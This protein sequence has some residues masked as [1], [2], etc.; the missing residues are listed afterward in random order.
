MARIPRELKL[1]ASAALGVAFVTAALALG[2]CLGIDFGDVLDGMPTGPNLLRVTKSL[3]EE[4]VP[5]DVREECLGGIDL[6]ERPMR[7][8][9]IAI[10]GGKSMI[11]FRVRLLTPIA[12]S[13]VAFLSLQLAKLLGFRVI[14]VADA[15]KHGSLLVEAGADVLVH[16]HNTADAISIIR[17]V[18]NN[19]LR[20]GLDAIGKETAGFLQNAMNG[21]G[22]RAHLVGLTGVPKDKVPGVAHHKVPVKMFHSNRIIGDSLMAWLEELLVRGK[23]KLPKTEIASGGLRGVNDALQTLRDARTPAQRIVVPI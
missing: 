16:R 10:W 20:F 11:S 14:C 18:T 13:S 9:W 4:E 22:R 17:G 19:R 6:D 15:I 21:D 23:L 3:Q 8:D 2:I 1:E 7:G 5:Q 12:S